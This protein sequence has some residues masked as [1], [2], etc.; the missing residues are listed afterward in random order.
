[1]ADISAH[2]QLQPVLWAIGMVSIFFMSIGVTDFGIGGILLWAAILAIAGLFTVPAKSGNRLSFAFAVAVAVP[3]V[4]GDSRGADLAAVFCIYSAGYLGGWVL[5]RL[6]GKDGHDIDSAAIRNS[7]GAGLYAF[8]FDG[9]S[10]SMQDWQSGPLV[11]FALASV[12]WFVFEMGAWAL[13]SY[14]SRSFVAELPGHPGVRRLAGVVQSL[15]RGC[16]GWF[17]VERTR[18]VDASRGASAICLRLHRL[19]ADCAGP[20]DI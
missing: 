3:V 20:I 10:A 12:V 9:L 8:T 16:I 1:M 11:A 17:L 14:G 7:L 6:G 4:V 19:S 18:L 13:T 15:H 2:D 5:A